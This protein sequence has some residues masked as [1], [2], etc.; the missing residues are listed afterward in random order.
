MWRKLRVLFARTEPAEAE[1]ALQSAQEDLT[2]ALE[3]QPEVRKVA[4]ELRYHRQTNHFADRIRASMR[5]A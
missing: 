2:A 4:N 3:R 1:S 5:G